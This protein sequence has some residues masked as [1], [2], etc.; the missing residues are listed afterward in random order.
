MG[1]GAGNGGLS[2]ADIAGAGAGGKAGGKEPEGAAAAADPADDEPVD[3]TGV[4]PKDIELVMQQ[5][6][7]SLC[8]VL[9]DGTDLAELWCDIVSVSRLIARDRRQSNHSRTTTTI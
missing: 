6:R 7:I 1:G 9:C 2:L 8:R 3:E 5:V 4:D